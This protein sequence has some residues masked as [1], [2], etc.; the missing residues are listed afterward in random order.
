LKKY[1]EGKKDIAL[2]HVKIKNRGIY[3]YFSQW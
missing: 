3:V 1:N 2:Y